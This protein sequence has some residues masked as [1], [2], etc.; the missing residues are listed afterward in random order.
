MPYPERTTRSGAY[1]LHFVSP[2]RDVRLNAA[3]AVAAATTADSLLAVEGIE[4]APGP[5]ATH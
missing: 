5:S 4:C 2:S 3:Y 1:G